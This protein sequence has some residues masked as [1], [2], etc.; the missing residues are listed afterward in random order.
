VADQR[1]AGNRVHSCPVR[2]AVLGTQGAAV[3]TLLLGRRIALA[4]T[5]VAGFCLQIWTFAE[6]AVVG[7][8]SSLQAYYFGLGIVELVLVMILLGIA[9]ALLE[10]DGYVNRTEDGARS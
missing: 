5:T 6:V 7:Y 10:A 2:I 4:L 8:V 3:T 9:P 1:K